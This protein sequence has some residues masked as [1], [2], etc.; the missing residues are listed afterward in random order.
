M[1][2]WYTRHMTTWWPFFWVLF[3]L[4]ITLIALFVALMETPSDQPKRHNDKVRE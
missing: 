3:G 1:W 2:A 4:W